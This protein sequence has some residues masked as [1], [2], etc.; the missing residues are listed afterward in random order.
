MFFAIIYCGG[1]IYIFLILLGLIH[2]DFKKS[3]VA[4]QRLGLFV[5]AAG[6]FVLGAYYGLKGYAELTTPR[7]NFKKSP[8]SAGGVN[9]NEGE[10][11]AP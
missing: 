6:F 9:G 5:L 3:T 1:A 11:R 8:P 4:P 2:K 10:R 7:P